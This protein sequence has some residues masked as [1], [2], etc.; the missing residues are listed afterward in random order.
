MVLHTI[1]LFI[2]RISQENI[3]APFFEYFTLTHTQVPKR[4]LIIKF[5]Q[6]IK[7]WVCNC[8]ISPEYKTHVHIYR[9]HSYRSQAMKSVNFTCYL[10][11]VGYICTRTDLINAL[12][13]EHEFFSP[14]LTH[15]FTNRIN[16]I[17]IY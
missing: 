4:N 9:P 13:N 10:V 15:Y 12:I 11:H 5:F 16:K 8:I 3:F 1:H 14:K 2:H 6:N 17:V 7:Y